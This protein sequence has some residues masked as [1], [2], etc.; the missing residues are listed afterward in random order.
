VT[1]AVAAALV[2]G[3]SALLTSG[4]PA[5]EPQLVSSTV[6]QAQPVVDGG[7]SD[8]QETL[9]IRPNLPGAN[10]VLVGVFDTRRPAPGPVRGV[11]VSIA[12]ADGPAHAVALTPIADGQ[13]TIPTSI[14]SSGSMRVQVVVHRQGLPDTTASY[15]W[16]VG[17]AP[18]LTHRPLV[19]TTPLKQPL[20]VLSAGLAALFCLLG[21]GSWIVARRQ[22][23]AS[24]A[25][26]S[27]SE[28]RHLVSS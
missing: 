21:L 26:A 8:L 16:V 1:E 17:G 15:R 20:Q 11:E 19:S 5:L 9:E 18:S 4:Q 24:T 13:W 7:A 27:S 22:S 28:P 6:D 12:G 25:D 14:A 23:R 2:L 10:V 3:L